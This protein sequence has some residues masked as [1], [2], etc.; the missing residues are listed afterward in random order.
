MPQ[1]LTGGT[2]SGRWRWSGRPSRARY[3]TD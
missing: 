2:W 1:L 3:G